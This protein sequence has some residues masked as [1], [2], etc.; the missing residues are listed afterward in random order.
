VLDRATFSAAGLGTSV[1][2]TVSYGGTAYVGTV[3]AAAT[4]PAVSRAVAQATLRAVE[5]GL[6]GSSGQLR[7]EVDRVDLVGAGADRVAVVLVSVLTS[8]GAERHAGAALVTGDSRQAVI[9]A[10]LAAVNR[11]LE[12][13]LG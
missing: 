2:V 10:T 8:R 4:A 11:R 5:Q 12:P 9:R 13:Y 6:G 3:E 1:T 7:A